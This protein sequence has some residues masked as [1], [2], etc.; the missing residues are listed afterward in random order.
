MDLHARVRRQLAALRYPANLIPGHYKGRSPVAQ[1]KALSPLD[2]ED[3]VFLGAS[4]CCYLDFRPFF[5]AD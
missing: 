1:K 2:R 3:F 4:R 5:L